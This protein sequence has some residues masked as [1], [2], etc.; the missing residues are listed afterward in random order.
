[1]TMPFHEF[2]AWLLVYLA[3]F[4]AICLLAWMMDKR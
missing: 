1:M 2:L 3:G 4:A